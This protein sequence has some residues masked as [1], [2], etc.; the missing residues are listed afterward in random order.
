ML[1][2]RKRSRLPFFSMS[3]SLSRV[4]F[5]LLSSIITAAEEADKSRV[6]QI[7][8]EARRK[9]ARR[10]AGTSQSAGMIAP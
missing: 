10:K 4:L 3:S 9:Q 5:S 6:G 8:L 1:L 2:T 7:L